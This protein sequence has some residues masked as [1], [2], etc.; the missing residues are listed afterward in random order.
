MTTTLVACPD[1]D[2]HVRA[3]RA[4]FR[5]VTVEPRD[6]L[7]ARLCAYLSSVGEPRAVHQWADGSRELGTKIQRRPRVT[8]H[9][10]AAIGAVARP[11]VAQASSQELNPQLKDRPTTL[12]LREGD[13]DEV[14]PEAIRAARAVL[15]G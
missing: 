9:V 13:L 3:T 5:E 11:A 2:A 1:Y 7:G 14:G 8:L 6:I 12:L 15:A 10:D 4:T